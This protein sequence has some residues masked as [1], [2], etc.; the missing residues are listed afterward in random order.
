[1]IR[2]VKQFETLYTGYPRVED[3]EN[4]IDIA[5]KFDCIVHLIFNPGNKNNVKYIINKES[6]VEDYI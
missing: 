1:M 5:K 4:C 6:R 2:E 3:I